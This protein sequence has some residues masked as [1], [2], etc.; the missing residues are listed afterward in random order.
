[1]AGQELIFLVT[2]PESEGAPQPPQTI[3]YSTWI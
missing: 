3:I 2:Q 1:M